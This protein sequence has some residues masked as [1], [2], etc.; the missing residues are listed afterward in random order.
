MIPPNDRPLDQTGGRPW[1]A[2]WPGTVVSDEDP[3]KRMRLRVRV[4][5]AYGADDEDEKIEDGELPWALPAQHIFEG[6]GIAWTPPVGSTVH[7]MFVGGSHERPVYFGGWATTSD[8]IPEH[9]SSYVP[10]PSTRVVKTR[11]GHIFEMRF[12]D[13]NEFIKL[14]TALEVALCLV[15]AAGLGGPKAD[16][17]T[18]AGYLLTVDEALGKVRAETPGGYFLDINQTAGLID[19]STPAGY[20]LLLSETG[21]SVLLT[22]LG[23]MTISAV[24]GALTLLSIA[25]TLT[26]TGLLSLT[27]AGI[28][29]LTTAGAITIGAAGTFQALV[30]AQFLTSTYDVHTHTVTTAPGTTGPPSP[31]AVPGDQTTNTTA[32]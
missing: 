19:M 27:G 24:A 15:D 18:P 28:A 21:A 8:A 7:V 23:A 12:E 25:F 5:H 11:N 26:A 31:L 1:Y 4:P 9:V 2:L 14:K 20:R 13:E 10:G 22:S 16:L 32:N 6:T 29:I 17:Q 3:E 30:T